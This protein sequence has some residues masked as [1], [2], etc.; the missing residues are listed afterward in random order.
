MLL[1]ELSKPNGSSLEWKVFKE[2][3]NSM[4][5]VKES[6]MISVQNV[7]GLQ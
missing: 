5:I 1:M 4:M 2:P 6:F 3:I 7:Y